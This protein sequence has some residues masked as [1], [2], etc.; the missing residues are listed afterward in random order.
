M[1]LKD[2]MGTVAAMRAAQRGYF[3]TRDREALQEAKRRERE[4][5]RAIAAAQLA[6]TQAVRTGQAPIVAVGSARARRELALA[7]ARADVRQ[8][9]NVRLA[10]DYILLHEEREALA[11]TLRLALNG[12]PGWRVAALALTNTEG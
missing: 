2:F 1:N 4:T 11:N 8:G 10:Q 5:D 6:E 7:A 12:T 3:E 9:K